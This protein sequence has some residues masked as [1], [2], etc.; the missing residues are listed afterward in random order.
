MTKKLFESIEEAFEDRLSDSISFSSKPSVMRTFRI[1]SILSAWLE[2]ASARTGLT[3]TEVLELALISAA[4]PM[5]DIPF[6]QMAELAK[7][8]GAKKG[9]SWTTRRVK[10]LI[11]E[12]LDV[13]QEIYK[14]PRKKS[15]EDWK[16][17]LFQIPQPRKPK[18]GRPR[19]I[20][21]V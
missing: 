21:L 7:I 19:K 10:S 6:Y 5:S 9:K 1:S 17:A 14:V 3:Q 20:I 11:G 2:I 15:V 4:M 12:D 13:A 16:T 8:K 18:R